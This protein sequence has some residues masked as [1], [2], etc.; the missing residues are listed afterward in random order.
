[1][2]Q[3]N[4]PI[5]REPSRCP[6]V[7]LIGAT[8]VWIMVM[9]ILSLR[10]MALTNAHTRWSLLDPHGMT[11]G[12]GEENDRTTGN[13]RTTF[14]QRFGHVNCTW[15]WLWMVSTD[16]SWAEK[17][18]KTGLISLQTFRDLIA[19]D[20]Q[21]LE[22]LWMVANSCTTKKRMVETQ[23]NNR[24]FT[25]V[26]RLSTADL[27]FFHYLPSTVWDKI[28]SF[29]LNRIRA[30]RLYMPSRTAQVLCRRNIKST[31]DHPRDHPTGGVIT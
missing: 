5:L 16:E 2:F 31:E 18:W 1:M 24:M 11:G 3:N 7:P 17:S 25:S 30:A 20:R 21:A 9:A 8:E 22:L 26:Y 28:C 27:D 6:L 14:L 15:V 19:R 12:M 13:I 29:F 23:Q 4:P 10:C